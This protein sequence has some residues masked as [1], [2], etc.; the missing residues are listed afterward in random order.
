[1]SLGG[2]RWD[3]YPWAQPCG[4]VSTAWLGIGRLLVQSADARSSIGLWKW[5]A[6][7]FSWW[8]SLGWHAPLPIN[9]YC[10]DKWATLVVPRCT[11]PISCSAPLWSRDVFISVP[12]WCVAGCGR[13]AL[14][15]FRDWSIGPWHSILLLVLLISIT[16]A[17]KLSSSISC[18][19]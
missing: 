12:V 19:S 16:P 13:C 10:V 5:G 11:W 15:D 4:L 14:W 18:K 9:S 8:W 3:F 17:L 2:H 6:G 7:W 1:M